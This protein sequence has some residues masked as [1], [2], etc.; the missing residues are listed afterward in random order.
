MIPIQTYITGPLGSFNTN[1]LYSWLID[2][3]QIYIRSINLIRWNNMILI[4]L[5]IASYLDFR[6]LHPFWPLY[7]VHISHKPSIALSRTYISW[8]HLFLWLNFLISPAIIYKMNYFTQLDR[9][10][11]VFMSNH[12]TYHHFSFRFKQSDL[13][14]SALFIHLIM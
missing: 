11:C 12:D 9:C 5:Y 13:R 3:R 2:G 4:Y 6:V 10:L 7:F 14:K 1:R 8:N